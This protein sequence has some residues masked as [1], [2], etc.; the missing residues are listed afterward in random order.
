MICFGYLLMSQFK[1]NQVKIENWTLRS[2]RNQDYQSSR[3]RKAQSDLQESSNECDPYSEYGNLY[4]SNH[5]HQS[6]YIIYNDLNPTNHQINQSDWIV[7]SYSNQLHQNQFENLQWMKNKTILLIGDSIDRNLV[8]HFGRRALEGTKGYHQFLIPSDE[9]KIPVTKIE[10]HQI[11]LSFLPEL[12]LT[13]YNW[14]LMGLIVKEEVPFFH[15][16]EDL[17]QDF[18]SKLNLFYLPL[19]EKN[20]L[21]FPDLVIFNTGFWDLDY[22][23]RSRAVQH[24]LPNPFQSIPRPE[25]PRDSLNDLGDGNPLS[26]NELSFHRSQFK[27]FVN[28]LKTSLKRIQMKKKVDKKIGYMYRSMQ[29][30]N[31]T[32]RNAFSATRVKQIDHSNQSLMKEMKIKVLDWG[33]MTVG[34]DRQLTDPPIHYGIGSAQ[35]IFG[36]MMLFYLKQHVSGD[37]DE[38]IGCKW[39]K[40]RNTRIRLGLD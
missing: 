28:S 18:Q 6:R 20:V 3:V 16:R 21:P 17:P 33:K 29:L 34:L 5:L 23:A 19:L 27:S 40:E 10:S 38:W 2:I 14:F 22:L 13:I 8:I 12:N 9:I 35:Y 31:A 15:P 7:P 1:L 32:D 25:T 11:G 24:P 4:S 26:L 37:E 30:G 36:D 39:I